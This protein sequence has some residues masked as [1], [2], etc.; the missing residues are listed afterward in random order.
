MVFS[1][2]KH[3]LG[4]PENYLIFTILKTL[5]DE[6]IQNTLYLTL[7]T[8]ALM[9]TIISASFLA[10]VSVSSP[11]KLSIFLSKKIFSGSK[12]PKNILFNFEKGSTDHYHTRAT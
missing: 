11:R 6:S 4:H 3:W 5:L 12:Y 7:E 1:K 10:E 2:P 9:H 8:K